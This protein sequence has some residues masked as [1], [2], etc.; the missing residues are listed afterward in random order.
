MKTGLLIGVTG[1][2]YF[3][4]LGGIFLVCLF[5]VWAIVLLK[6]LTGGKENTNLQKMYGQEDEKKEDSEKRQKTTKLLISGVMIICLA[7]LY[8]IFV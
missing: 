6:T 4:L 1:K 3:S 8:Y 2:F 5:L 7:V